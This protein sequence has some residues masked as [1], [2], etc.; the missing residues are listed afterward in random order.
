MKKI[1]GI[2]CV[3]VMAI[4]T[5]ISFAQQSGWG[6][7]GSVQVHPENAGR[8]D[9]VEITYHMSESRGSGTADIGCEVTG[10][11]GVVHIAHKA[12]TTISN[13]RARAW[14]SY[15]GD[16]GGNDAVQS[17]TATRG[18]Y[19]V[20]CYW[21]IAGYGVNGKVAAASGSFFIH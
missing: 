17:T 3:M 19:Q 5:T 4:A 2:V 9:S 10:P 1:I 11:G 8:G 21:Y 16:F 20:Q 7:I 13:G 15:P 12:S 6:G 14:F 18:T